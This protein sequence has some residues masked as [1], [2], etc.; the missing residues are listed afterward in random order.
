MPKTPPNQFTP[1]NRFSDVGILARVPGQLIAETSRS[2]PA[3][4]RA[5]LNTEVVA[6]AS[7]LDGTH[8]LLH[9][10]LVEHKHRRS[11]HRWWSCVRAEE[12]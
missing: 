7:L 11:T 2:L 3:P 9:Y 5:D 12:V 4:E 8:V 6:D 1:K 10:V